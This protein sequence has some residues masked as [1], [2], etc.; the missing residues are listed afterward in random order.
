MVEE[1]R[2]ERR[3]E[4][5]NPVQ[6]EGREPDTQNTSTGRGAQVDPCIRYGPIRSLTRSGTGVFNQ[7]P[8]YLSVSVRT[9]KIILVVMSLRKDVP[10]DLTQTYIRTFGHRGNHS[11]T[12]FY[13]RK[14]TCLYVSVVYF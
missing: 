13:G 12:D 6:E 2:G 3:Q 10:N 14:G 11:R 5:R 4:H 1:R 8:T 9:L 7:V